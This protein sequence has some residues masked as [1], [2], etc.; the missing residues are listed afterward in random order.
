MKPKKSAAA[1][2]PKSFPITETEL[3]FYAAVTVCGIIARALLF[4]LSSWD[5]EHF[6]IPWYETIRDNGGFR[7]VGMDIGD[8]T[9]FYRYFLAFLTTCHIPAAPGIK[10][11]SGIFEF[12]GAVYAARIAAL[13]FPGS[14]KPLITFA[15]CFCLPSVLFNSAAWGQCDGIYTC[16]ILMSLYYLLRERDMLSMA[17]FGM[18]FAVKLQAVFFAPFVLVMLLRKRLRFRSVLL[19]PAIYVVMILPA[20]FAGGSFLNL[21]T[22][23]FRQAGQYGTLNMALPNVWTLLIDVKEPAL[24]QAGVFFAGAAMLC[25]VWYGVQHGSSGKLTVFEA[26]TAAAVSCMAVPYFLPFMHERY[27]FTSELLL[28]LVIMCRPKNLWMLPISQFCAGIGIYGNLFNKERP[29]LRWLT[30]LSS[31]VLYMLCMLWRESLTPA[32]SAEKTESD[33]HASG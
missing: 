1:R 4:P 17:M 32:A 14:S 19:V 10:V 25:Y 30:L 31:A 6:L 23:Y 26:V 24:G 2:P 33:T 13:A 3:T 21:L 28:V 16:F 8:Y 15:A 22:V 12:V 7:A 27:Y 18:A 11:F 20:L 29:D 5:L 9:P